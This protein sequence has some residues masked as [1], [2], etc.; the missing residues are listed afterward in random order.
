MTQYSIA[1]ARDRFTQLVH[2]VE[3]GETVEVTRRGRRVAVL[4][5]AEAYD[6]LHRPSKSFGESILEFRKKHNLD[7]RE[8]DEEDMTDEAFDD[9][10]NGLRDRSP[11]RVI[12]L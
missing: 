7:D 1:Q 9:F 10:M 8:L 5:S 11:G 12:E 6:Q 4:V 2:Q 3:G